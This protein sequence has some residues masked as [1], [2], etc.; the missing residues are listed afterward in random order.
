MYVPTPF[1][2]A[3]PATCPNPS[4]EAAV[5]KDCSFYQ[6]C[7]EA[8]FECGP[9]GYPIGY[10]YKY[11]ERFLEQESEF[12]PEGQAW[13]NG[14]LTCLKAALVPSVE[15]PDGVTCDQVKT[16]A[17]DSHVQCYIDNGFCELAFDVRHPGQTTSFILDLMKVYQI[18]DFASF[19]AIKQVAQ[20]FAKCNFTADLLSFE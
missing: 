7:V 4:A 18:S 20:V 13:I 15:K 11:C 14:T 19:I 1:L 3:Y 10:G 16:I 9:K 6:D 5:P 2:A 12:S 17:F 8:T